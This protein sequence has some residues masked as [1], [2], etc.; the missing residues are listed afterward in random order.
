MQSLSA[1]DQV[2]RC[3]PLA[4]AY[5][6]I[7]ALFL[8]S[9]RDLKRFRRQAETPGGAPAEALGERGIAAAARVVATPPWAHSPMARAELLRTYR[10]SETLV[11]A[12]AGARR[13]GE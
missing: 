10:R 3:I 12:A 6:L 11:R 1:A 7:L 5:G 9:R 2:S 4:L 13:R 8:K